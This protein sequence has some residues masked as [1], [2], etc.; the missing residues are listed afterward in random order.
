MNN[1]SIDLLAYIDVNPNLR[2]FI[3]ILHIHK[4]DVGSNLIKT[5]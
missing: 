3:I 2:I 1:F 4:I 5:S